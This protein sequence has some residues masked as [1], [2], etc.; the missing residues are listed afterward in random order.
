MIMKGAKEILLRDSPGV[1]EPTRPFPETFHGKTWWTPY[2]I[3]KG[4]TELFQQDPP[5]RAIATCQTWEIPAEQRIRSTFSYPTGR[6]EREQ[7][8]EVFVPD[9]S[10]DFPPEL[11]HQRV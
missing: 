11:H 10:V 6:E 9:V 1:C 7:D 5:P 2:H 8:D 3:S 4:R